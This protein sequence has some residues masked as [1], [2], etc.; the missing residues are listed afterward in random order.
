MLLLILFIQY[1]MLSAIISHNHEGT[2]GTFAIIF[3]AS[4][5][6]QVTWLTLSSHYFSSF[7]SVLISDLLPL[8]LRRVCGRLRVCERC[9]SLVLKTLNLPRDIMLSVCC[10]SFLYFRPVVRAMRESPVIILQ[11]LQSKLNSWT[12]P[13]LSI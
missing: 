2:P 1:K 6:V 8:A 3:S 7:H 10:G 9:G 5:L 11:H 12:S 4:G 13:S